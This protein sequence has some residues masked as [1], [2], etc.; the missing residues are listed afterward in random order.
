MDTIQCQ[1]NIEPEGEEEEVKRLE[2]RSAS[3]LGKAVERMCC[4]EVN[5]VVVRT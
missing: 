1:A 3:E 2:A 5:V 4:S